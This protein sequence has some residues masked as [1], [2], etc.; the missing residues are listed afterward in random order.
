MVYLLA[1]SLCTFTLGLAEFVAV[2]LVPSIAAGTGL[3]VSAVGMMVGVYAAGV[4]IGAPTLSA[5]LARYSRNNVL[6]ISMLIFAG[7][8]LATSLAASLSI[9]LVSR[10]I[11]GLIHGVVLSLAAAAAVSAENVEK[12]GSAISIVFAGLT[13]A[14]V[15]GVP[16]GTLA[17]SYFSWQVV[18]IAITVTSILGAVALISMRTTSTNIV[19]KSQ[20]NSP[21]VKA[22][23]TDLTTLHPVLTTAAM[24]AGSFT[25]FTYIA[26]LLSQTTG[27]SA[28]GITMMFLLY[29]IAASIGN[30][31]GGRFVDRFGSRISSI[32]VIAGI[33]LAL[34]LALLVP[35]S[36]IAMSGVMLVW[37][38]A[39]F[40]AVPI[41]QKT[42]LVAA[43]ANPTASPDVASGMNIAAFNIGIAAGSV[44]GGVAVRYSSLAPMAVGLLPLVI[45]GLLATQLR[46]VAI[47]TAS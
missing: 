6:A 37:G 28:S 34:L 36:V 27:L 23:L 25:G 7:S 41:M 21:S 26:V 30:L 3:N 2:S 33:A 31:L 1:L 42:V 40:G 5:L 22:T 11:A 38:V 46:P 19:Q 16:L 4:S 8:N 43:Q 24:Y 32:S 35:D 9:L 44:F 14:L 12:S 18:F 45:A 39:S 20:Q 13:F 29:G 17:G 47:N 10:F 15:L